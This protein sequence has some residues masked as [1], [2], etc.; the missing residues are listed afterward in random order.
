MWI[1]V[2]VIYESPTHIHGNEWIWPF[3]INVGEEGSTR[4]EGNLH[5]MGWPENKTCC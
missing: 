3:R 5:I 2:G 1:P 4:V